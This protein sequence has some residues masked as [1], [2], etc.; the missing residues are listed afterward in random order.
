MQLKPASRHPRIDNW[1][2]KRRFILLFV[3][4]ALAGDFC[5][6][7]SRPTRRHFLWR[8][9]NAPAPFYLV[10]SMHALRKSD[11]PALAEFDKAINES[12]KLIFERD[13]TTNDQ[14]L[15]WRKLLQQTSYP[16][17]VTI[18]QRVNPTTFALLKRISR[19]PLS[20]YETQKPSAIAVFNLKAQGMETVSSRLSVDHYV[21][22]RARHRAEMGW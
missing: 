9:V 3:V 12:T 1:K 17:G 11:Y 21:Y 2:M 14:T 15:L 5:V 16:R 13:P 22:E 18:Q 10:G 4:L 7:Q 20:A 8:V 6:A 19:I